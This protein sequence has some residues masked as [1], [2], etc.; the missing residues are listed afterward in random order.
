MDDRLYIVAIDSITAQ[1]KMEARRA[2]IP[3]EVGDRLTRNLDFIKK[4]IN[5]GRWVL[6]RRCTGR[7]RRYICEV[8]RT[9]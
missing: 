3:K 9:R 5:Q 1:I 8:T 4:E 2:I 6:H 7:V